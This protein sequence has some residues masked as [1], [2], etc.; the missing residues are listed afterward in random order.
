MQEFLTKYIRLLFIGSFISLLALLAIILN[1]YVNAGRQ[2]FELNI[3]LYSLSVYAVVVPVV[4]SILRLLNFRGIL[5]GL[6]L[7]ILL[8]L[9]L[10]LWV[11][12]FHGLKALPELKDLNFFSIPA[13]LYVVFVIFC[14][15]LPSWKNN[16]SE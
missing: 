12:L 11:I 6:L 7:L 5:N 1:K 15:F 13:G 16:S 3:V 2:G 14:L 9:E 4:L 8:A 10:F